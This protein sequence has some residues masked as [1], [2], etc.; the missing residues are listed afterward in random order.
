LNLSSASPNV[1]T[2]DGIALLI[3]SR[4]LTK[5]TKEKMWY[6]KTFGNCMFSKL[7]KMQ[8]GLGFGGTM[9]QIFKYVVP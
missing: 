4:T 1:S 7:R 3:P 6:W 2:K 9:S 5:D 8:S